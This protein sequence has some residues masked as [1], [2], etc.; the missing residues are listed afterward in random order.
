MIGFHFLFNQLLQ[1]ANVGSNDPG[2]WV[3]WTVN[4]LRNAESPLAV[5]QRPR[6]VALGLENRTDVVGTYGDGGM[7]RPIHLLV[8]KEPIEGLWTDPEPIGDR[9]A[10]CATIL[11]N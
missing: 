5:L 6:Q 7:V 9:V 10:N 4:S 1:S 11:T 2:R 3:V 8:Y